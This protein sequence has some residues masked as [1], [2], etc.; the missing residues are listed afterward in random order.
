MNERTTD[1]KL[2]NS[3]LRVM[4]G[5]ITKLQV[6]A[7]VSSDDNHL[8]MG[9]GVS[10]SILRA[11]GQSITDEARKHIPLNLG[12]VVVTSAGKLQAKYIFHAVTIDYTKMVG[13]T[14]ESIRKATQKSLELA[15]N[16][17]IRSIAF[18]ALGTGVGRFP[19]QLAAELMIRT[20]VEYLQGDTIIE[21]VIITLFAR[22]SVRESDL[23]LFYE[24]TVALASVSAQSKRLDILLH[25]LE[26]IVNKL[27]MPEIAKRVKDIHLEMRSS[28]TTLGETSDNLEHWERI[29]EHSHIAE[30]SKQVI[31]VSSETQQYTVWTD[32]ELEGAVIRTKLEGILTRLNIQIGHRN[33]FEIEKAKYGGIGIPPRLVAAIEEMDQ[34]IFKLEV[35]E[36]EAREKLALLMT[37]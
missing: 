16:L 35:H 15:D 4:Y 3:T 33:R 19:F 8:T 31:E 12:D 32:K 34:E 28:Q 29:Q 6:D 14:E 2:N 27:N 22:E 23:N 37:I 36:K 13:P 21:Q 1:Y 9:G 24:R 30:L 11:G 18:P 10:A 20:I 17:R 25:E 5:D 7:L 26:Q